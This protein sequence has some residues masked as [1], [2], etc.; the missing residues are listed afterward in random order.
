MLS[1]LVASPFAPGDVAI[2]AAARARGND[3]GTA[4][5]IGRGVLAQPL[6]AQLTQIRCERAAT[7]HV[8]GLVLSG[9]KFKRPL[10]RRGFLAE[11]R[12]LI[13]GAFAIAPLDE[14]DLWTTVPL[15]AGKGIAVSG[16]FAVATSATVFA[17]TVPRASLPRLTDRLASGRDVFWDPAFAKSLVTE[18]AP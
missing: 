11:V 6:P 3:R 8:C 14:V 15:A 4:I 13:D 16:D 12:T 17:V 2:R 1:F 10:D 7:H 18:R 5:A 9:V